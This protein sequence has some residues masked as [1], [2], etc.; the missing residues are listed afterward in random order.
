VPSEIEIF[1]E[2]HKGSD[3]LRLDERCSQSAIDRLVRC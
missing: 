3:P 2:Y 1:V